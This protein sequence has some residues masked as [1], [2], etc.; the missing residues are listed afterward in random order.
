[1]T[2]YSLDTFLIAK[3]AWFLYADNE[4]ADQTVHEQANLCLHWV[5]M[6]EV[7]VRP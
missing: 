5:H 1:M 3:D 6:S 7:T 4:D 2:E